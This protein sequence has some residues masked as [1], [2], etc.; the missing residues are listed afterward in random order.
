MNTVSWW[1]LGLVFVVGGCSLANAPDDIQPGGG[2]S[3]GGSGNSGGDGAGQSGGAGNDGGGTGNTGGMP[4]CTGNADCDDLTTP[5]TEGVC[6]AGSCVEE[7]LAMGAPCGSPMP[8]GC[9]GPDA[10]DG[11]GMCAPNDAPDGA[12]CGDCPL[13]A[14]LCAACLGGMCQD[15]PA[16]ASTNSFQGPSALD[17]WDLTGGWGLYRET[18]YSTTLPQVQ[19]GNQVLGTDGNRAKPYPGTDTE[20]DTYART[21]PTVIPQNLM[22]RSWH[23]DEGSNFTDLDRK[24]VRISTDGGQSWTVV[25]DCFA[26]PNEMEP[27]CLDNFGPRDRADWDDVLIDTGALAGQVGIVEFSYNT[28]D[29]FIGFELGWYIEVV[30]F[31]TQCSCNGP[32]GCAS[33]DGECGTGTCHAASGECRLQP[34]NI[35]GVCGDAQ[36]VACNEPDSCGAFGYCNENQVETGGWCDSC[37]AGTSCQCVGAMCQD[38]FS[39]LGVNTFDYVQYASGWV[40][41]G[42]WRSY[43]AAPPSEMEANSIVFA[44]RVFGTDGNRQV[45]YPGAE[46]E[47]STATSQMALLPATLTFDSW[48][49]DEGGSA[50]LDNKWIRV[51]T[52]GVNWTDLVDCNFTPG[53]Q[54]FCTFLQTRTADAWDSITVTVPAA[55]AGQMGYVEFAYDTADAF[56]GFERGW[57]IDN[58]NFLPPCFIQ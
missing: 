7:P 39:P 18:P 50:G 17:G 54:P 30:N 49:V 10:C 26:G 43:L 5:C 3:N 2:A 24:R 33:L 40:T 45:P 57:Y 44:S 6:D 32:Q 4:E 1:Q 15:C 42:D 28:V 37:A 56:T 22:F 25:A 16:F 23:V 12:P 51:S 9:S 53:G 29:E 55:M 8:T 31:A 21:P 46:M 41:T 38:C 47:T 11:A 34:A 27:F 13:G 14:G 35:G 58:L 20:I 36:A 48:H 19:F 52:D